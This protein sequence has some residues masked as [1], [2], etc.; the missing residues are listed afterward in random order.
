MI[1]S[2]AKLQSMTSKVA[3]PYLMF[4]PSRHATACTTLLEL[5]FP[6]KNPLLQRL[7]VTHCIRGLDDA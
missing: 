3:Y 6:F 7:G 2:S 5:M 1:T 4:V